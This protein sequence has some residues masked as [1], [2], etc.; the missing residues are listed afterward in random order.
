MAV[1]AQTSRYAALLN[2]RRCNIFFYDA[3][4]R[5]NYGRLRPERIP[6]NWN[7]DHRYS[8]ELWLQ[9]ALK[10]HPWRVRT[11]E[12]ADVIFVAANFSMYCYMNK[13]FT[14]RML[15]KR[16]ISD[17][18]LWQASRGASRTPPK[19]VTL[20]YPS[21]PPWLGTNNTK[22]D[23]VL[24]LTEYKRPDDV[25]KDGTTWRR[26][27]QKSAVT[28]FV[29]SKPGWL[30]GS[31]PAPA[32]VPWRERK[33]LFYTGHVPKLQIAQLR[34]LIWR[35][36][37]RDPRVTTKSHS[38]NCTIGA[39]SYCRAGGAFLAAQPSSFFATYCTAFCSPSERQAKVACGGSSG[40]PA[41][42]NLK[43][44]QMRCRSYRG[45]NF[46]DEMADYDR[47]SR[48]RWNYSEYL[49]RARRHRFCLV[50]PGDFVSTPKLSEMVAL[51]GAG[52]CIPVIVMQYKMNGDRP[53]ESSA[54]QN[55]EM[56]LPHSDWLDYCD[57]A[58]FVSESTATAKMAMV[59]QKLDGVSDSM[60]EAK[61]RGLREARDAFSYRAGSTIAAPSA[62]D[63]ILAG[64]CELAKQ[65][66]APTPVRAWGTKRFSRCAIES[67]ST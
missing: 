23:G 6:A 44:F 20:Q 18:L 3:V 64:M 49:S 62:T 65:Y 30:S 11:V 24:L 51:G 19:A 22:P 35:Q 5:L 38:I 61:L 16:I 25:R 7:A 41:S 42:T 4:E 13:L 60:A 36:V 15:W 26:H 14:G 59:L 57:I 58:Y 28:P 21:C 56:R 67:M 40:V 53:N 9:R 37:R 8:T 48:A 32:T 54:A 46:T 1:R 29:V 45:V 31:A 47:D 52:G 12:E 55:I 50:V 63:F 10:D 33:L 34:Y 43:W 2:E 17:P 66:R 39:Y 27:G